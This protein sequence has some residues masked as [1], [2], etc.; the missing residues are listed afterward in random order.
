MCFARFD[1]AREKVECEELHF[2]GRGCRFELGVEAR[3]GGRLELHF[4]LRWDA[5]DKF[6]E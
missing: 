3:F 2:G 5:A 1:R 6:W 4:D